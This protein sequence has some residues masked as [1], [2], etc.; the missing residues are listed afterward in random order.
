LGKGEAQLAKQKKILETKRL[1][2]EKINY[3]QWFL[4]L[5]KTKVKKNLKEKQ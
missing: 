1:V 5:E 3:L 4:F 2:D